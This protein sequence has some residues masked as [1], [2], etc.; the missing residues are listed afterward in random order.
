MEYDEEYDFVSM[1][2]LLGEGVFGWCTPSRKLSNYIVFVDIGKR[3]STS[4][5]KYLEY[6]QQR[7][8]DVV[9]SKGC[10]FVGT[11]DMDRGINVVEVRYDEYWSKIKEQ[12][13]EMIQSRQK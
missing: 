9:P 8:N 11:R 10:A 3:S 7:F 2:D 13:G 12:R 4:A 1:S 5:E 6:V